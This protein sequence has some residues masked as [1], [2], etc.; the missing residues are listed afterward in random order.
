[1]SYLDFLSEFGVSSAHPGG[2][3]GTK[4]LLDQYDFSEGTKVLDAGCGIGSTALFLA[5]WFDC[6]VVGIDQHPVMVAKAKRQLIEERE[7]DLSYICS[8]LYKI[9][10]EESTFDVIIIES[11]LSFLQAEKALEEF[12]RVLKKDGV[13]LINE[14]IKREELSNEAEHQLV[15]FYGL[16]K[17]RTLKEW[18]RLFETKGFDV[19]KSLQIPKVFDEDIE[20]GIEFQLSENINP[21]LFTYLDQHGPLQA[22]V[23]EWME[24]KII[25]C[26]KV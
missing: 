24:E 6:S 15:S 21:E 19:V 14:A 26:K 17:L 16:T 3:Q 18:R 2:I 11:V 4:A 13:M 20:H 23:K 12:Y 5:Q 10:A 1:M 25:V 7:L 22:K 9:P 8:S